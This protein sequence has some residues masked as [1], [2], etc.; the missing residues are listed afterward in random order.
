L[1]RAGKIAAVYAFRQQPKQ[2]VIGNRKDDHANY[3]APLYPI[4]YV[5]G[6][7]MTEGEISETVATPYM[8]FNLGATKTRQDWEGKV[9]LHIFESPLVRLMKIYQYQDTYADGSER[10]DTIPARS[11]IIYRYYEQA[12]HDLGTGKVPSIVEAAK[13]LGELILKVRNQ[14]CGSDA[15]ARKDFK[16]YFGPS[17]FRAEYVDIIRTC[18]VYDCRFLGFPRL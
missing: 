9:I 7:A 12:D 6:Y 16:G 2:R 4:I 1:T 8:G 15:E 17:L 11:I 13:G 18:R 5:R 3:H 10:S 14:V